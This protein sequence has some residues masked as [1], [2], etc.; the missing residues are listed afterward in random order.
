LDNLPLTHFLLGRCVGWVITFLGCVQCKS[1]RTVLGWGGGSFDVVSGRVEV[2]YGCVI[3]VVYYIAVYSKGAHV[4]TLV[5]ARCF[6]V[7][8]TETPCTSLAL[9][10]CICPSTHVAPC[11][12]NNGAR[13]ICWSGRHVLCV[14]CALSCMIMMLEFVCITLSI[15]AHE[16]SYI[17][18]ESKVRSTRYPHLSLMGPV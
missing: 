13:K 1:F 17:G 10:R 8:C 15:L 18:T 5:L 14:D 9:I 12:E 6:L 11:F 7:Y 4:Y 16:S 3:V 2:D